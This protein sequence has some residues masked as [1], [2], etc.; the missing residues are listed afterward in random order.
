MRAGFLGV[1]GAAVL[2]VVQFLLSLDA[3]QPASS[4]DIVA[5]ERLERDST[6]QLSHGSRVYWSVPA[7]PD[8]GKD[9]GSSAGDDRPVD[10]ID[11]R[12]VAYQAQLLFRR[13]DRNGDGL[14]SDDELPQR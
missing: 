2:L 8:P 13:L 1:A 5:P 3:H 12:F 6:A 14:L 10:E 7:A 4:P 9:G 11:S